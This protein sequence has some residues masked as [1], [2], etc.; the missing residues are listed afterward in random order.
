MLIL[1]PENQKHFEFNFHATFGKA[2][3][4]EWFEDNKIVIGFSS[5]MVSMVSTKSNELGQELNQVQVGNAPIEAIKV[6][7]ELGKLAVASQGI[8]RF[9]GLNDW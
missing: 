8:I 1:K 5:G 6:H 3:T 4:F 9:Y 7:A 2:L